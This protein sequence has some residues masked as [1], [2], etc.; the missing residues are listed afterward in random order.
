MTDATPPPPAADRHERTVARHRDRVPHAP[1]HAGRRP[2]RGAVLPALAGVL[3]M[4]LVLP[5]GYAAYSWHR[6]DS[7]VTRIDALPLPSAS[8]T[9]D[10]DVDGEAMNILLVG[11][12]HR[13]DGAS[14]EVLAQ[15]GTEDDGGATNTD[16]MIVLHVAA[17]GRSATMISLPRD[18]YVD[19]PGHGRDKLNAA[20]AYGQRDGGPSGGAQL[21]IST[22]QDLT[23]LTVD[24]YV[25]VSLLG[26]YDVVQALGPV[27]VCLTA[28]VQDR[29]SGLDLPAGEST[30]DARQS[31]A[32]VRQR[33]GLPRG[34]LDRQVRQQYFLTAEAERLLSAG[35]LL[36]PAKLGTV[37][38]AVSGSLETDAGLDFLRLA[39]QVRDLR[40]S[41]IRSA[42]IPITGTPTI[43]VGGRP[44]SIVEVDHAAM[45]AFV[46]DLIGPSDRYLEASA[47]APADVS[48]QVLN[49]AG[50]V[51][52]ATAGTA[53]LQALGF[54][55]AAPGDAL[56][57]SRTTVT[58]APGQEARAKA[59]AE[60][61]PGATP[62]E[63][64][65]ATGVTLVLGT[66]GVT[67]PVA[68]GPTAPDDGTPAGGDA[69]PAPAPAAPEQPATEAPERGGTS[70]AEQR[71]I[72]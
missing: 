6:F 30:L 13:P 59:V 44:L 71:C 12:D 55:T 36:N 52:G 23:G 40:P 27:D 16:T 46:S 47:A 38:D 60:A 2:R 10:D 42:T 57:T 26:F 7:G 65:D 48:V 8:G 9:A 61:V 14:P 62:V 72:N 53:A 3:T 33:H 54:A 31:L 64:A 63:Q 29:W 43:T 34:D 4:L 49:G 35:T 19:I 70:Y 11:D 1:R 66:D 68:P 32:F 39:R 37:L 41:E 50:T 18:S 20:F 5:A 45:P 56:T 58:Y 69:A 67:V 28:P 22:V 25:R 21:L 24:H 15:L 51:G 17:D